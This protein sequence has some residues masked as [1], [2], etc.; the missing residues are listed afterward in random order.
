VNLWFHGFE[1]ETLPSLVGVALVSA[2]VKPRMY[3]NECRCH[4]GAKRQPGRDANVESQ[5]LS[6]LVLA[7][8]LAPIGLD[9]RTC[10]RAHVAEM[11]TFFPRLP[12]LW[13]SQRMTV[14]NHDPDS[15][16][17]AVGY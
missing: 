15:F 4:G 12:I 2:K 7:V 8:K 9:P 17:S 16:F 3:A 11:A 5:A 10:G 1:A 6:A 14:G 13:S